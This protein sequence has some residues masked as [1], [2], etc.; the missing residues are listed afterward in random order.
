MSLV[1]KSAMLILKSNIL[2]IKQGLGSVTFNPTNTNPSG[3]NPPENVTVVE[4][5]NWEIYL[6]TVLII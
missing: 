1:I 2:A 6:T 3:T 4:K 5:P